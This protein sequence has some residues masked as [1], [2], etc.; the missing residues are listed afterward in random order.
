MTVKAGFVGEISPSDPNVLGYVAMAL[1]VVRTHSPSVLV[2][3]DLQKRGGQLGSEYDTYD[4][5]T[6]L[7]SRIVLRDDAP[8]QLS[9]R[10]S[11]QRGEHSWPCHCVIV[12]CG[13]G[14]VMARINTI[15]VCMHVCSP[16]QFVQYAVD[17]SL[18]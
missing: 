7:S 18:G 9:H 11:I 12:R 17:K 8:K 15:L 3:Q 6:W 1:L 10:Q 2:W 16:F 13:G 14:A 4:P 5:P